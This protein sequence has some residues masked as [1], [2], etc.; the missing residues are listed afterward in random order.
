TAAMN[1]S[2]AEVREAADDQQMLVGLVLKRIEENQH[3][4]DE[5]AK[6]TSQ[7]VK[8]S[9]RMIATAHTLNEAT[10]RFIV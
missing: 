2:V 3:S 8:E 7:C 6:L 5:T 9:E 10:H 1:A 4:T